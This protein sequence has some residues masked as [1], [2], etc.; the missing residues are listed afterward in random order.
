MSNLA[1]LEIP[2]LDVS[3]KNYMSWAVGANMHLRGNGLLDT[4]DK[5]E[6]TL[7]EKKAKAIIFLLHHI[8]NSLKE[9]YITEEDPAD[10]W[11]SLKDRFD[12]QK[13]V[14]LPKTKHEWLNLWFQDYKSVGEYNSAMFE[15]TSRMMLCGQE[16]SKKAKRN[17]LLQ[18]R[19]EKSLDKDLSY[20]KT[21]ADLYRAS[22]DAKEKDKGKNFEINFISD[23]DGPSFDG[24]SDYTHLDI[25]D[26]LVDL[27]ES[28]ET[29][30]LR[31]M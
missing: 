4:I 18:M 31:S 21:F 12:H 27:E 30:R 16:G 23:E 6:T 8:D 25:A 26:F 5:S 24:I 29:K 2:T 13:Y 19:H 22:Q 10:L 14:I 28:T 1:K 9:E 3:G 15:I 11:Q 20:A 7:D 17:C